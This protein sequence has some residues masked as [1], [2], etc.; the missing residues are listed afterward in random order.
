MM[1]TASINLYHGLLY[2]FCGTSRSEACSK[3]ISSMLQHSHFHNAEWEHAC[4]PLYI[5]L[6]KTQS[7]TMNP[8][9][10]ELRQLE[11]IGNNALGV[12]TVIHLKHVAGV[13]VRGT[14]SFCSVN[15]LLHDCWT[16]ALL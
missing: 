7:N 13:D 15:H 4:H 11:A 10:M 2:F 6:K 3:F 12:E 14:C 1:V 9:S 8:H 5:F 16:H